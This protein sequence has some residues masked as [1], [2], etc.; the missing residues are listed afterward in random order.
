LVRL[1]V[2]AV[3]LAW[4]ALAWVAVAAVAL[5]WEAV[6]WVAVAQAVVPSVVGV[7]YPLVGAGWRGR[8]GA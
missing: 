7:Y 4:E 1:L 8:R 6:A 3:A 5:A 2:R